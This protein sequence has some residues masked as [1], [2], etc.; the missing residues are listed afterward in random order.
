MHQLSKD[1]EPGFGGEL[2]FSCNHDRFRPN[3]CKT[4][5][6]SFNTLTIFSTRPELVDHFVK[7]VRVDA[8]R[9]RR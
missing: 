8:E 4:A 1:W 7:E 5:A 2:V 9:N 6:P 3:I